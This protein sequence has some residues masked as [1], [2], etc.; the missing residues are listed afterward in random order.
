MTESGNLHTTFSPIPSAPI[1]MLFPSTFNSEES[2]ILREQL[3]DQIW[4]IFLDT[5]PTPSTAFTSYKT[6]QRDMYNEARL[7]SLPRGTS[8]SSAV[9][10]VMYNTDDE[11]TEGSLTSVFFYRDGRWITPPLS[12]GC[13]RGTTRRWA[14]ENGLCVEE[15]IKRGSLVGGDKVVVSNGARGFRLGTMII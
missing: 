8:M 9:E 11:I 6:N 13:Q 3:K 5:Q 10:V 15:T 7:R 12:S 2:E 14:L 4:D 1:E